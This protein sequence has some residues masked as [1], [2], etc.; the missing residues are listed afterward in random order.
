MVFSWPLEKKIFARR[1]ERGCENSVDGWGVIPYLSLPTAISLSRLFVRMCKHNPPYLLVRNHYCEVQ[2]SKDC[3][4]KTLKRLEEKIHGRVSFN[5]SETWLQLWRL[6][7]WSMST[8]SC[9]F[10][11]V[12]S[13]GFSSLRCWSICSTSCAQQ[14]SLYREGLPQLL[15]TCVLQ[16][17]NELSSSSI[18]VS[19][20]LEYES[21]S[22]QLDCCWKLKEVFW[23]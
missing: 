18:M 3:V 14:T 5:K 7:I 12:G 2:A 6:V 23:L 1:R 16:M 19:N 11:S 10:S 8:K 22:A 4:Q 13:I 17:T 9:I 21:S 15:H 20:M